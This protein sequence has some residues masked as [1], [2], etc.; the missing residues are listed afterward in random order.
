V[1]CCKD[2]YSFDWCTEK[3]LRLHPI[4]SHML[5]GYNREEE[6]RHSNVDVRTV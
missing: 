3:A 6:H 4:E 5:H 2:A 1:H